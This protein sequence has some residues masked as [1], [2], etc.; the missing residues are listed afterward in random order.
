MRDVVEAG[1]KAR[2]QSRPLPEPLYVLCPTKDGAGQIQTILH[3]GAV[4]QI[5]GRPLGFMHVISGGGP[6]LGRNNLFGVLRKYASGTIR[7]W[8][9][10]SDV[11]VQSTPFET[12]RYMRR[13][14]KEGVSFVANIN[15]SPAEKDERGIFRRAQSA[16]SKPD[17]SKYE[18]DEIDALPDWYP[19]DPPLAHV[20]FYYGAIPTDY[21]WHYDL[22]GASGTAEDRLFFQDNHIVPRLAKEIK[23]KHVTRCAI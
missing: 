22:L 17:G 5:L 6:I 7:G 2:A 16:I 19:I 20:A 13:A 23:V 3:F 8:M 4:A 10:D 18:E 15:L 12:V 11:W 14:D 1:N 21:V 9:I